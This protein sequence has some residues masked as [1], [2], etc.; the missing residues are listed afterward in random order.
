[1]QPDL[2]WFESPAV[3]ARVEQLLAGLTLAQ[4]IQ[5]VTTAPD[6][7]FDE[8]P[9]LEQADGPSGVRRATLTEILG[10]STAMPATIALAATWD[11]NCA[12]DY[13]DA[14]G[15]E[16]AAL[17][18]HV[19]LGPGMDI[20]RAPWSGR[21][22]ESVGE[23]ALLASRL[24]AAYVPALQA[25]RVQACLKHYVVNNQEFRRN[26]CDVIVDDRTLHEVYLPPFEAGVH[27]GAASVMGSYN[28]INGVFACE[29]PHVLTTILRDRFGFRGWTVTDF[30]AVHG[31]VSGANAGLD[32]ELAPHHW[33]KELIP[34]LE[35]GQVTLDRLDEMVRRILRPTV[36]L[37]QVDAPLP[38]G[39]LSVEKQS[40]AA[41][42]IAEA[43][44]VL[45]KNDGDLLPL[46]AVRSLAVIGSDA[47]NVSAAGGGSGRCE[48]THATPVLQALHAR[49]GADARVAYAQGVD[50]ITAGTL[51]PGPD[52]VPSALLRTPDDAPGL[53][54]QYFAALDFSGDPIVDQI[55]LQAELNRILFDSPALST[56]SPKRSPVAW[57]TGPKF[58]VRWTGFL[59]FPAD[60][61]YTLSLSALGS[62]RLWLDDALVIDAP[63][64]AVASSQGGGSSAPILGGES[65]NPQDLEIPKEPF[66]GARV[67]RHALHAQ[68][69]ERRA[70]RI[71]Y[72]ADHPA[73]NFLNGA[74]FRFGMIAPADVVM[75]L[76][77]EAAA[78]AATCDVAV[79]VVRTS[80]LEGMDRPHLRLPGGQEELIRAV[81]AANPRTIVVTMSGGPL[82][83][84]NW[85]AHVPAIVSAWYAGQ[86]QGAAV[87][88]LLFGDVA[89]RGRLPLTFPRAERTPLRSIEQYPGVD[90]VIRYSEGRAVGYR[91]YAALGITPEYAFGH[92]LTYTRFAYSGLQVGDDAVT[93]TLTNVGARAG[94]ET[95][96]AYLT[97]PV[98]SGEPIKLAGWA[99]VDLQPGES[100]RVTIALD[101]RARSMWHTERATWSRIDGAWA[102]HVGASAHDLHL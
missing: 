86:E 25:H 5:L 77:A 58:S 16:C 92:G 28:R 75:P 94:C 67:A 69:G 49:A 15:A 56:S 79:V 53:R 82:D 6:S 26:D 93:F 31:A 12:R 22:F 72:A 55:D 80:E 35:A 36:G 66:T 37:G 74:Q 40:A 59:T 91:G 21:I 52:A 90:G 95:A 38:V 60:G 17:G 63:I 88:R 30:M 68:A 97:P 84:S 42:R 87:A 3:D 96:Q 39:P 76:A 46:S 29:N 24:I 85:N 70:V 11:E 48:P 78:L 34:A 102:V 89:P 65:Q 64:N 101:A 41:Q 1:M 47:D 33:H 73:I 10:P 9:V 99:K 81:S 83:V 8:L 45:L 62:A 2:R 20:A 44:M 7:K 19:L 14:V 54:A 32:R 27:A 61:E 100:R 51:V 43:A 18:V 13:G 71:E 50:P 98:E 57:R 4:K 23:D